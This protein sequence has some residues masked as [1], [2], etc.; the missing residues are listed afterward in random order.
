MLIFRDT[1]INMKTENGRKKIRAQP[2]GAK[3]NSCTAEREWKK[4]LH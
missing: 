3:K 4:T 1:L 2:L